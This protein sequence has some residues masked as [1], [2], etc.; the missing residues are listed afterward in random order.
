MIMEKK[1]AVSKKTAA[2]E[3]KRVLSY[4]EK[5][6]DFFMR[7]TQKTRELLKKIR[8]RHPTR[9]NE[10]SLITYQNQL[11]REEADTARKHF[12]EIA[13]IVRHDRKLQGTIHISFCILLSAQNLEDFCRLLD[14]TLRTRFEVG[15]SRLILFGK[16]PLRPFYQRK[17]L[18]RAPKSVRQ[19]LSQDE[20]I[21]L[22][23]RGEISDY[24][25]ATPEDKH[26]SFLVLPLRYFNTLIA[27][28][29]LADE[30]AQRFMPEMPSTLMDFFAD[31]IAAELYRHL[32]EE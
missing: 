5:H 23:K 7:D 32:K 22:P 3:H 20:P 11:W 29:C 13:E 1:Q 24:F 27:A 2:L 14:E 30:D 21:V 28:L 8:L 6:P 17:T 10:I 19:L 26:S 9:G 4:L 31:I 16:V 18:G 12:E 25:F 15:A